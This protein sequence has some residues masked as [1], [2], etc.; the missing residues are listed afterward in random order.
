MTAEPNS[1]T[2][3][4]RPS[5]V[6]L[7]ATTVGVVVANIYYAQP[8]LAA[9]AKSFGLSVAHAGAI[10]ML[11]QAGTATGMALFVPLGDKFERRSLVTVLLLGAFVALLAFAISP[12]ILCLALASFAVGAFS[13]TV[14]VV[15]PFA[16]HLASP[17]ERGRVVGTLISGILFGILLARSFS[18][19]IGALLSWRAVYGIAAA[20][21]IILA[22]VVRT[23]LPVSRPE[24][25]ISWPD[26]MRSAL[27]LVRRHSLLRESAILGAL[28]FA[29]FSAFW[30]TLVFFLE[31]PA[32][33]FGSA[34]AVAGF[35]GLVGAAGA[36]GAPTFGH[37][38]H[39]HGP[40]VTIQIA[41]WLT[42]F[43]F[44]IMGLTGTHFAGLIIGVILMDLGVQAAHIANQ[45]RI[46]GI[47]PGARSR[48]NMVYMFCYF[49]G[50]GLGS[51]L[52][53]ICW[54][55]AGWWGVCGF[56]IATVCLAIIVE[57]LHKRAAD[58][59]SNTTASA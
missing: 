11:S 12:N 47:D 16:A 40:R 20:A 30:T 2:P 22:A 39:K 53:A 41:L 9:I 7:M 55:L 50:G 8:L 5:T 43:A 42:I 3:S 59:H 4:L 44:V 37:L 6:W 34:S 15:V 46:Y 29:G 38:A 19:T 49:A 56:G 13:A 18:G 14:H 33:H 48:L 27:Q 10:A 51:W 36:A 45:T 28:F 24:I 23:R 21:M 57:A 25:P 32:Y 58:N 52:G 54:H 26:L 35:F 31:S 1:E 17:S